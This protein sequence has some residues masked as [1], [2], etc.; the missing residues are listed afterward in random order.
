M[1]RRRMR[2]RWLRG[3][4]RVHRRLLPCLFDGKGRNLKLVKWDTFRKTR[5]EGGR[6]DEPI[7][8]IEEW[9]EVLRRDVDAATCDVP[10]EANLEVI[11]SRLLNMW[12]AKRA[13]QKKGGKAKD[14]TGRCI[15]ALRN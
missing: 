10:P 14:T 5:Q 12:E 3:G 4:H 7:T 9:T 15:N 13:L 8:D 2:P 11:D 1:A 6:G